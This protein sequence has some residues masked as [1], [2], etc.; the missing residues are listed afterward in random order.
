M[1]IDIVE[2][3]KIAVSLTTVGLNLSLGPF[4]FPA[5][6]AKLILKYPNIH[7]DTSYHL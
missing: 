1:S 3:Q 5:F 7:S 6:F 2:M 4:P